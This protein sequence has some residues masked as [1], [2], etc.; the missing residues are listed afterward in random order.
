[1]INQDC[2]HSL[3]WLDNVNAMIFTTTVTILG[4]NTA[5]QEGKSVFLLCRSGRSRFKRGLQSA[6]KRIDARL[7]GEVTL[8]A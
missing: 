4:E 8:Y 1:M 2:K 3:N 7:N 6:R 5:G